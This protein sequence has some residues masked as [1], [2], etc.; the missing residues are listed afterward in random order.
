MV[1][2]ER[3]D[4]V[5]FVNLKNWGLEDETIREWQ[6]YLPTENL[7][8]RI[9]EVQKGKA[10]VV[11]EKGT[12]WSTVSG[13]YRYEHQED[14]AAMPAVGDWVVVSP[15][16]SE[17]S[18]IFMVAS[19]SRRTKFSRK[20]A[21]TKSDEQIIASNVDYIF[22]CMALN[23]DFNIKRLDRYVS[24]AWQS[25][26]TP[27]ILLTKSDLCE[28]ALSFQSEVSSTFI[29]VDTYTTC[30]FNEEDV[31]RIR[32]MIPAGKTAVFTG[33]SGVGKSTLINGL[34]GEERQ[35]TKSLRNDDQGRHTTTY[36]ELILLEGG[37]ILVDTP[38]MREFGL[39]ADGEEGINKS[40][41]DI[42]TLMS[43]CY[44]NNCSH[45]N[46]KGCKV[47]EAL[48]NGSLDEERYY[49]YLKLLKESQYMARKESKNGQKSYM[50]AIGKKSKAR[51]KVKY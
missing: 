10:K 43:S 38:G 8:A 32:G 31:K 39:L 47:V 7:L 24:V 18:E 13:R 45:E 19:F 20:V 22:I 48:E 23:N 5:N 35:A 44:F 17:D 49:S 41:S 51:K 28:D 27:I 14:D 29:G 15:P 2:D 30:G 46:E 40:F 6:A 4:S 50:K 42:E 36:R 1:N 25:G 9:I 12:Y 16:T 37:G 33:S 3:S 11:T 26:A 34:I 21:G